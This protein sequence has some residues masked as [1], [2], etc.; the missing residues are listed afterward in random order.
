MSCTLTQARRAS[1]LLFSK[2]TTDPNDDFLMQKNI[3]FKP[4]ALINGKVKE[5]RLE[6]PDSTMFTAVQALVS[7]NQ[8]ETSQINFAE[9]NR[10]ADSRKTA[11]AIKAATAQSQQLSGVQVTLFSIATKAQ[12]TYECSIIKSRVLAGVIKVSPILQSMYARDWTVKP[13]GDTDVIEKQQMI[14]Q[15]QQAWPVVQ[16]TGASTLFLT[17]LLEKMFPDSAARYV[18]AI[19]QQQQQQSSQQA[20][21][22]Q[23][24]KSTAM[25]VS[26]GVQHLAKHPEY[27]SETGRVHAFPAVQHAADVAKQTEQQ[28]K[29][30]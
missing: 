23:A 1:Y 8:Q 11:T 27:F 19:N 26:D 9:T 20:Q 24:M 25:Q 15:M 18:A 13:S 17:D 2:D 30:K 16:N 12:Y 22:M 7:S 4:G 6:P 21:Q 5:F 28:M 29:G 3:L 14:Q 10:Q